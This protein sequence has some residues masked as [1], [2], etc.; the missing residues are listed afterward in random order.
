[1]AIHS[2]AGTS[3]QSNSPPRPTLATCGGI[4]RLDGLD[5]A[6][7]P[8]SCG[9]EDKLGCGPILCVPVCPMS[10]LYI[11]QEKPH[12]KFTFRGAQVF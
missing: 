1:V 10:T 8:S 3:D 2:G 12:K 4:P 6:L 9:R 11:L 7:F 5:G